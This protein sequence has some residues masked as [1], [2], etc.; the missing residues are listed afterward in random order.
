VDRAE[1][2]GAVTVAYLRAWL[3]TPTKTR[4]LPFAIQFGLCCLHWWWVVVLF[5]S[6]D[7]I[8]PASQYRMFALLGNDSYWLWRSLVVATLSTICLGPIPNGCR[9]IVIGI[10]AVWLLVLTAL[11]SMVRPIITGPGAYAVF[12]FFAVCLIVVCWKGKGDAAR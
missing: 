7:M 4:G 2:A 11:L 9:E 1:Q 3:T 6:T 12:S 8:S 10:Q 5:Q